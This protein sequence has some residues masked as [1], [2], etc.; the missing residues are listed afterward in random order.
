MYQKISAFRFVSVLFAVVA[1]ESSAEDGMLNRS[2]AA[3]TP[4]AVYI[5][6]SG[7]PHGDIGDYTQ[8]PY[9]R[10]G[11]PTGITDS[12]RDA[13]HTVIGKI[14]DET[15]NAVMHTGDMVEGRWGQD[16]DGAGV[17][18][19]VDTLAHQ[20]E[21]I[22]V[23][24]DLLYPQMLAFWNEH[25]L[26]PYFGMGDHEIGD[27]SGT[28]PILVNPPSFKYL[29]HTS[30][31]SSWNRNFTNDGKPYELRPDAGPHAGVYAAMLSGD[32]ALVTLNPI[33]KRPDGIHAAISTTQ[34]KWMEDVVPTLRARG[35][36]WIFV[37]CEIPAMGPNRERGTSKLILENGRQVLDLLTKLNV[38]LFLTA[39]F[40]SMTAYTQAGKRPLHIAHGGSLATGHANWLRIE[41]YDDRIEL[42]LKALEGTVTNTNGQ[43]PIWNPSNTITRVANTITLCKTPGIVGRAT[44]H[45][46]GTVTGQSGF[47]TDGM[48]F[49][50]TGLEPGNC[51]YPINFASHW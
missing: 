29:A 20:K 31:R 27:L 17:Y 28:G 34:L 50:P 1:C 49:M 22:R 26:S 41:T 35:A 16:M 19:A 43:S 4:N 38:D 33:W 8:S 45:A 25:G 42:T 13:L 2:K 5:S 3:Q 51:Q 39:E 40:H 14:A 24:A 44:L 37:Q 21:A 36:R 30:W 12:W 10:P 47:L 46:D 11:M 6:T 7:I 15:P 9:F 23:A 18:G 32:A 48:E